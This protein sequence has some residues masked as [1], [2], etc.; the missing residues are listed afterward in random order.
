MPNSGTYQH[1][2]V[3]KA[4][5]VCRIPTS[6]SLI[7][8]AAIGTGFLTAAITMF[9]CFGFPISTERSMVTSAHCPWIL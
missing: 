2:S 3:H 5:Q 6:M 7:S 1:Y 8:A 9:R 4:A